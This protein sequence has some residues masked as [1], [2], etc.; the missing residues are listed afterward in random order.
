M[1]RMSNEEMH[2]MTIKELELYAESH[3]AEAG[4]ISR[5]LAASSARTFKVSMKYAVTGN[6]KPLVTLGVIEPI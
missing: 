1:A 4:R 6:V 2:T 5:I 3:P